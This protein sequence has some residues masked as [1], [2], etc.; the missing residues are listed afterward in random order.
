MPTSTTITNP[1]QS[2]RG[3]QPENN[4]SNSTRERI[5]PNLIS[6]EPKNKQIK[7]TQIHASSTDEEQE[8]MSENTTT[9]NN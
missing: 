8:N 2:G 4:Q 1:R 7:S 5:N 6:P 3:T 9:A